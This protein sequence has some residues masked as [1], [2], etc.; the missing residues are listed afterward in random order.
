MIGKT[1][2][3]GLVLILGVNFVIVPVGSHDEPHSIQSLEESIHAGAIPT[4]LAFKS[5]ESISA[6]ATRDDIAVLAKKRFG[7]HPQLEEWTQLC[8]RLRRQGYAP[9]SVL[10]RFA[11]LQVQML[12][13]VDAEKNA[14]QI[15]AYQGALKEIEDIR[16]IDNNAE[17]IA[18]ISIQYDLPF[19]SNAAPTIT[20]T[21][22][23]P[24]ERWERVA[25]ADKWE[26]TALK[27]L[28]EFNA[29]KKNDIASARTE[30]LEIA[31]IRF[32]THILAD[33]WI[34]LYFRLSRE[35]KGRISDI[36]RFAELEMRMLTDIDAEKN[37]E[38][39]QR[40]RQT[41]ETYDKRIQ[42]LKSEGKNPE[43]LTVKFY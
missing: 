17:E 16:Q 40:H 20:G 2:A 34:P 7:N 10:K 13:D 22:P 8:F 30:L 24:S 36:K 21:P 9:L 39:I 37:A 23:S 33:E 18:G 19:E 1:L 11:E 4:F 32:G 5:L 41:L 29:L 43:T 6:D 25:A 42:T 28:A 14:E 26:R 31:K 15:L 38:Q 12:T 3:F 27:H 35:G